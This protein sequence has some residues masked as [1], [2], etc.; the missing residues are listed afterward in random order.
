MLLRVG[1]HGEVFLGADPPPPQHDSVTDYL[2]SFMFLL[3]LCLFLKCVRPPFQVARPPMLSK[4][5]AVQLLP[6]F[7]CFIS[8]AGVSRIRESLSKRLRTI[9]SDRRVLPQVSHCLRQ[10][11]FWC[12]VQRRVEVQVELGVGVL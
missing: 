1:V 2:D 6:Q 4:M 12:L 7:I 9:F 3:F 8:T 10:S 11:C 5:L